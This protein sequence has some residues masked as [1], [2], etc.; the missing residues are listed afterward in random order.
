M[1]RLTNRLDDYGWEEVEEIAYLV[2]SDPYGLYDIFSVAD[3]YASENF[4]DRYEYTEEERKKPREM[5]TI[6]KNV[7]LK[8]ANIEDL[9]EKY[10][11][12]DLTDLE[13]ALDYYYHRFDGLHTERVGNDE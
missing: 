5:A 9:M 4:M 7:S 11:I 3:G 1:S 10:D 8:L 2:P 13:I 6:L 12:E